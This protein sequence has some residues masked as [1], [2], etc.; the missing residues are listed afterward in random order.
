MED[1]IIEILSNPDKPA[2][3]AIEINDKL[4]LTS[5]EDY[6]KV[7]KLLNDMTKEGVLY[8]SEKKERYLLLKNS[9]LIRG[10]LI[11]NPKG[12][13]FVEMAEAEAAKKAIEALNGKEYRGRTVKVN[14]ALP[15][16]DRPR[17]PRTGGYRN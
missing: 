16:Q 4:G 5:I 8:Y 1:K 6:K 14:E 15:K 10:K 12:F 7:S 9:H 11:M 17:T 3:S 2:M 13:G